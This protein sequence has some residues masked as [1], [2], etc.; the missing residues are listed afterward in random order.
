MPRAIAARNGWSSGEWTP[1]LLG[2]WDLPQYLRALQRCDNFIVT[3]EGALVR[4]PPFRRLG[5][6]KT[7]DRV[8][9]APFVPEEGASYVVE[10]GAEY[11]RVWTVAGVVGGGTPVEVVTP[12]TQDD[13]SKLV[14]T[15][16][17]DVLY[18]VHPNYPP[19]KLSRTGVSTFTFGP[20]EWLN[21]RA[22]LGPL[23]FNPDVTATMT[24]TW[25]NITITMSENTFISDD[26]GRLFFLRDTANT[27]AAY[28]VID[29]VSSPTVAVGTGT[30]R[31]STMLPAAGS[32][33]ALGL[34]SDTQGCRAVTFHESRLWFGGFEAEKDV[35]VGSVSNSFENFE[36]ISP[37]IT[38]ND[39]ANADKAITRRVGGG[40]SDTV[41]WLLSGSDV[42]LVGTN[43]GEFVVRPGISGFLTPTETAVRRTT[44]RGSASVQPVRVDSTAFF[45]QRGNTRI[46]QVKYDIENDGFITIDATLLSSQ[47]AERGIRRLVYQQAPWSVL[48]FVDRLDRLRGIT[49]ES[50]QQVLGAHRHTLGGG[51]FGRD[52]RVIDIAAV[53]QTVGSEALQ[54]VLFLAVQRTQNGVLEQTI[55]VL[56]PP[57]LAEDAEAPQE[58]QIYAVE[59]LPH[60]DGYQNLSVEYPITAASE[61]AGEVRFSFT[62]TAPTAGD[63]VVF[64]GL[65]WRVGQEIVSLTA[66]SR[67]EYVV[68]TVDGAGWFT[69]ASPDADTVEL[70]L[71][72]LDLPTGAVLTVETDQLPALAYK[73]QSSVSVP[74][75][76][77]G[78]TYRLF[79]D[80]RIEESGTFALPGS[81]I[82]GG[83]P[84]TSRMVTMPLHL[85]GGPA[86]TDEGEPRNVNRIN[87][88]TWA[89]IGGTVAIGSNANR[90]TLLTANT[91]NLMSAPPRPSYKDVMV[92]AEG[93]WD[94]DDCSVDIST[95]GPY[96]LEVLAITGNMQSNPR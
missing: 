89:S 44:E 49:L 19:Q 92:P 87:V 45:V 70:G 48:W 53:P 41:Q 81:L 96:P 80:G 9:L 73:V 78:D 27:R 67:E 3:A 47:L 64:R 10:F 91:D 6:T 2:R 61:T 43:S 39:S 13:L 29:T 8:V 93:T 51:R 7:T 42:M 40:S 62:G 50:D 72:D 38:L 79:V 21:G 65:V 26:V 57:P 16:D 82:V 68:H 24:G 34:F 14:W 17:A 5:S 15:Q 58:R 75:A 60:L 37:D 12:Y 77:N 22:P 20:V 11:A 56:E 28:V 90:Q 1:R 88:R 31:I 71:A 35:I 76:E 23:N 95:D 55:E 63:R 32:Q 46:R 4:R 69:I 54:D 94:D 18:V 74:A 25:P 84:Y 52:P 85:Q 33:W 59:R 36:T 83:Y 86:P 66:G 30:F